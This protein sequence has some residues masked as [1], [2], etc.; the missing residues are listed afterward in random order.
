MNEDGKYL[1]L[2]GYLFF[3][4]I[5]FIGALLII[6]IS[7][8][9]FF[10]LLSFIPWLTYIYVLFILS[11]PAAVFISVFVIF[12][13]RTKTHP[14]KFVKIFSK[15]VFVAFNV[16]WIYVYI[17]DMIFF[18][19]N[20]K[21]DIEPYLSYNTLFLTINVAAIF[22]MGV[23][24]ALTTTKELDWMEKHREIKN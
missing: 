15:T 17:T 5:G 6:M 23:V 9:L 1:R 12:F 8:R 13:R 16:S 3:S 22:L 10:G 19:K 7:L 21:S 2:V 24:Q 14:S 18:Y 11:V 20:E 4:I